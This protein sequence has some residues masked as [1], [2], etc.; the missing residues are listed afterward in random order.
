M[1]A[2]SKIVQLP[3]A[4]R[5]WLDSTLCDGNFSGYELI[6]AEL[7]A[8]GYGISKTAVHRYGQGLERKLAAIKA[9]TH[10]ASAIA[11][12]APDDADLRSAAV[13]SLVQTEVF[14]LLVQ[15]QEVDA[16][17]DPGERLKL[18][19]SAA[20]SVAEMSRASIGNKKFQAEVRAKAEAVAGEV[21]AIAKKGGLSVAAMD[22]IRKGILGIAG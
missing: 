4:V 8:R 1:A 10:A 3:E 20:R 22:Q 19:A 14:D 9:S 12:A 11:A 5:Q 7:K 13:I 2:R 17:E 6:A 15:M 16:S 21:E 18:L